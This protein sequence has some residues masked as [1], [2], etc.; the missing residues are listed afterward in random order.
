MTQKI[1]PTK[2]T[3]WKKLGQ[4]FEQIKSVHM[5]DLFAVDKNRFDKFSIE[6]NDIFLDYSK[7]I[8]TDETIDLLLDLT[9]EI[10]LKDAIRLLFTGQKINETEDRAV[11]HTALRSPDTQKI[12]VDKKNIIPQIHAVLKQM[13][14]FCEAVNSGAWK[15]Y[16][17]KSI[18]DIVNIGI[19]G[20]DLGP[21][22]A[23][24]A[25][26]NYGKKKFKGSFCI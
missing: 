3:A 14:L 22:M 5:K 13:K 10:N 12:F 19:G 16:T 6:F 18:T 26:K 7:N 20:S 21:V 1:N 4:H 24:E 25:L 2:I 23:T 17:Q 8:I 9:E 15:G 11:L